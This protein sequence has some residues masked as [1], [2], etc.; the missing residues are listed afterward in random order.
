ME[1]D[2][3]VEQRKS[4]RAYSEAGINEEDIKTIISCAQKAP[5]WKNTQCPRY[6]VA[7]SDEAKQAIF[8]YLPDFNQRSSK[9][10]AYII[11]TFKNGLS[12]AG[13][14]EADMWSA[15]DLGLQN[16]LLTLKACELGYDTLIMGLRDADAIK[17]YFNIATD[18]TLMAVIAIGKANESPNPRPRKQLEEILVIK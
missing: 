8:N 17:Q 9:N 2:K 5:S 11:T 13:S 14:P 7:C 16:M 6:Y 10:A 15:Y 12:G 4:I 3:L 18:E 1:F